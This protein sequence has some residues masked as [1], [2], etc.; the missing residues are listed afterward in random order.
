MKYVSAFI[1]HP[2]QSR[3][4]LQIK[5][6]REAIKQGNFIVIFYG[7]IKET[8]AFIKQHCMISLQIF[9]LKCR[10]L[11]RKAKDMFERTIFLHNFLQ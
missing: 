4:Y 1:F 10:R 3:E 6:K 11:K 8:C 2:N 9:I 5:I 7:Y